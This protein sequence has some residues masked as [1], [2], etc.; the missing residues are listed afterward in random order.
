MH[1][2]LLLL[3]LLRSSPKTGYDVLRIVQ[4]H[5]DL[6]ADLK[7][8]NVYYLLERLATAGYVSVVTE[9]GT[10]GR[11]GERLVYTLTES[12]YKRFI[13]LLR[14]VL[15]TFEPPHTGVEVGVI[16]L[17]SLPH[18]E[19]I[20]LLTERHQKVSERRASI[21]QAAQTTRYLHERL[22]Q[23][24]LLMLM[25]AELTWINHAIQ[26]LGTD[27]EQ[28]TGPHPPTPSPAGVH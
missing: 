10:R 25:D 1:K 23:D 15:C 19:A 11:R 22:A 2:E 3:G 7:Q 28:C 5:G 21:A 27:Y 9:G 16:F 13:T 8:G 26:S 18:E 4:T 14:D 20:D 17:P 12:G 24:H 6:Y